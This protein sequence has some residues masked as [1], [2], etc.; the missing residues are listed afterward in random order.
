M[1]A[2]SGIRCRRLSLAF[3][4]LVSSTFVGCGA[5]GGWVM[6]NSG[7][8]YY[9]SGNYAMARHEFH[10]A[11]ALDPWNPD[12]RHNLAMSLQKSGNATQA[13]RI[14]RHNLTVNG[15]HQPTYHS[16][17]KLMIDTGRQP[18]AEELLT[19]WAG[20]Q[21]YNANAHVELAW[22]Q[23]E[24][25]NIPGAEQSL[26]QALQIE[27]NNSTA[28]ANLGQ[29]YQD[30]GEPMRATALYQQSLAMNFNQPEVQSRLANIAPGPGGSPLMG[31]GMASPAASNVA[32]AMG[33]PLFGGGNMLMAGPGSMNGM[34]MTGFP[35]SGPTM[36]TTY[37]SS[38]WQPIHPGWNAVPASTPTLTPIPATSP[39][40]I[41]VAPQILPAG[42]TQGVPT[43][44]DSA[45]MPALPGVEGTT[46]IPAAA[47]PVLTVPPTS[48]W[49]PA[50]SS[51]P[52]NMLVRNA[53]PAHAPSDFESGLQVLEPF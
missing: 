5:T 9:Q 51:T 45:G 32:L 50:K 18:E 38:Q 14:L 28:I 25:G 11:V 34:P 26:R 30:A 37:P 13:E 33:T 48:L 12:Y 3:G 44:S 6:N 8:G 49:Q 17:A 53:D 36:M 4:L 23:R 40:P 31:P 47:R 46:V 21:P 41:P 27:P 2:F 52:P 29:V 16:L 7:M 1:R 10:Q 22:M 19:T 42:G 15:A 35:P 24:T 43:S 39:T 20:T